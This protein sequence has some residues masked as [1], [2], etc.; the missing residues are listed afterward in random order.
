MLTEDAEIPQQP[1]HGLD[2]LHARSHWMLLTVLWFL[3]LGN[4]LRS[5]TR[6]AKLFVHCRSDCLSPLLNTS[7]WLPRALALC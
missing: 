1:A 4:C 7:L 6:Q 2:S 5:S 3:H